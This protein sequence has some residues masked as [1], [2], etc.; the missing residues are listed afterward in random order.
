MLK[1]HEDRMLCTIAL[2]IKAEDA[3]EGN[4]GASRTE[5][6]RPEQSVN[7]KLWYPVAEGLLLGF[8]WLP[9]WL[10]FPLLLLPFV[11]CC[12]QFSWR[13]KNTQYHEWVF[14]FSV[15]FMPLRL[16]LLILSD[17]NTCSGRARSW[18]LEYSNWFGVIS[19]APTPGSLLIWLESWMSKSGPVVWWEIAC[20]DQQKMWMRNQQKKKKY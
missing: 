18:F 6:W 8:T 12:T 20:S 3:A 10:T 15:C 1:H 11:Q 4:L 2:L 14:Q 13:K 19:L 5:H 17:I 7:Q 16:N 9:L